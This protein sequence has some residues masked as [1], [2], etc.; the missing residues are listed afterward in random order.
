[1]CA[2]LLSTLVLVA[3]LP[4]LSLL[5]ERGTNTLILILQLRHADRE[6]DKQM[7]ACGEKH[8]VNIRYQGGKQL[9]LGRETK[10]GRRRWRDE[11]EEKMEDGQRRGESVRQR[12]R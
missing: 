5:L 1:M 7:K 11:R 8:K 4:A 6:R 2:F 12:D 3:F 9:P 10:K